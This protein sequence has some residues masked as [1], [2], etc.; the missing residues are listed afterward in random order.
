MMQR[1]KYYAQLVRLDRPIGI[2]LLLWPTFWAL[3]IA[4][5]GR[6]SLSLVIIFVLGVV[7]MRSA[8]CAI[9]DYAD[10]DIDPHVERTRN[11]PLA[12][13]NISAK[14]ALTVCLVL[15]LTAFVLVLQLNTKTII[16]SLGAVLLA[17]T[18]PFMKRIHSLPQAHLGAAFAWGIPMA[19]T[20]MTN[21]W[22]PLVAWVLFV[23]SL[24]WT[25][26]YDTMYAMSD[27]EDDLKIGVKSSAIFFGKHDKLIIGILQVLTLV[28]LVWVGQLAHLGVLYYLGLIIAA[29]FALYEQYLIKDRDRVLC[30]KA[31]LNNN[32]F[33]LAVFVGI[34]LDYLIR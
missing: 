15:C 29:G 2:Y 32:G 6:P 18:Y 14:E 7:L 27:R 33:G 19:F 31:F 28:L 13:G 20:A 1:L 34:C 12:A 5:E 24:C 23:A 3:W 9:N 4:S 21:E 22:P 8:G 25:V 17:L 10:R 30:F 11:R 16:L 26:A